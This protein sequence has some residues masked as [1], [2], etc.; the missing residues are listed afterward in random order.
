[1]MP[2]HCMLTPPTEGT[3]FMRPVLQSLSLT[4]PYSWRRCTAWRI[5][6]AWERSTVCQSRPAPSALTPPNLT[7]RHLQAEGNQGPWGQRA[8][9][10]SRSCPPR[11]AR[12]RRTV[13]LQGKTQIPLPAARNTPSRSSGNRGNK[14]Y[15][16][17]RLSKLFD[18]IPL[19]CFWKKS[20]KVFGVL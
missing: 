8:A 10:A 17:Y 5:R 20:F 12:W 11:R 14:G 7:H 2:S 18:C 16:N 4:A 15:M 19:V 9:P 1:M 13:A 6:P 3:A